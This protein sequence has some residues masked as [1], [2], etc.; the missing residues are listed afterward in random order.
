[1]KQ[2]FS[3]SFKFFLKRLLNKTK[4]V[5]GLASCGKDQSLRIKDNIEITRFVR[6]LYVMTLLLVVWWVVCGFL[7]QLSFFCKVLNALKWS[8]AHICWQFEGIVFAL[9]L[10]NW[11]VQTSVLNS[12]YEFLLFCMSVRVADLG[13]THSKNKYQ[14]SHL[15]L[16]FS[17]M[18][19]TSWKYFKLMKMVWYYRKN[20]N[21]LL[22]GFFF[23]FFLL[24]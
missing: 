15:K 18:S 19:L 20:C 17:L 13:W 8:V 3:V 11:H 22:L 10:Y 23:N 24:F 9:S 14:K 4:I 7:C 16:L 2:T 21:L 6:T 1:M 12:N 5:S